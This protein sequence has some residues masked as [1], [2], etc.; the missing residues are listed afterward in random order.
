MIRQ[1]STPTD[2][3]ANLALDSKGLAELRQGAKAG[4]PEALK[5]A[6]TQFEAMFVNMMLKSMREATPQEGLLD[7]SQTK[8]FTTMLD[9]QTSQNIAKKGVGLADVLVRQLSKTAGLSGQDAAA[10]A[11]TGLPEGGFTKSM[12][13]AARLQRSID[14][15]GGN[16]AL[17]TRAVGTAASEV[18]PSTSRHAHVRAFADK[19][20]SH[21]EEASRATG[22]PAKFMLGQ[23]ALESG[24]GRREIKG[25]NGASSHN[26]FG[27][28]AGS[29][30]KGKTVDVATTEYVNGRAQRKIERFRAYD[31]YADSF[32]D[33]AKLITDNPRYEKV[34]A[35]A[36]DAAAFAR[37]LQ[38]AGYATDPNYAAKLAAVINKTLV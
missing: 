30:W 27:I 4:S 38:K 8:M 3:S 23:A 37:N 19:L 21:A 16:A 10:G 15:A 6:A 5:G 14:A 17:G 7:N 12:L 13:D 20:A 33:Y 29:D 24:W 18:A 2:L 1:T 9:Q 22:I 35:S 28:K 34:L 11:E 31:S 26:L 36:G 25:S 32:K